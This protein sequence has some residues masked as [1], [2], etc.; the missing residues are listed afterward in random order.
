MNRCDA[1]LCPNWT[2]QGCICEV[3]DL[4]APGQQPTQGVRVPSS[5]HEPTAVA[6]LSG[7]TPPAKPRRSRR[8]AK[9]AGTAFE[10][11][12]ARYLA[13]HVD[14]RIER[15][16]KTGAKD[17]GDLSGVRAILDARVVVETKDYG[18]RLKPAEWT[19]EVE[20]ERGNDD[21]AAGVVVAKR[22]GTTD[23]GDQWVL[24]TVRDLVVLLAGHRPEDER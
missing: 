15:R 21:A 3:L 16:A 1:E 8:S 23:P 17:R 14:D 12:I 13:Q 11:L 22:R 19:T 6:Y 5:V 9:Q 18:G 24:M 4:P 20:L 7:D 10:T 2:G